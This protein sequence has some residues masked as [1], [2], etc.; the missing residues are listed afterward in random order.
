MHRRKVKINSGE[1]AE[2]FKAL[3]LKTS[4]AS[5]LPWVQIPPSP[6]DASIYAYC[7]LPPLVGEAAQRTDEGQNLLLP[8]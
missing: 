7:S 6:P 3:V 1:V 4:E 8:F 2:R 5:R